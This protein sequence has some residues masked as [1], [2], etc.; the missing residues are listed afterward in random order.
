MLYLMSNLKFD[1]HKFMGSIKRESISCQIYL[2][3]FLN[4]MPHLFHF[5]F[6]YV[7]FSTTLG[8]F[9]ATPTIWQSNIICIWKYIQNID[10]I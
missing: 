2:S 4:E 9:P 8:P 6:F 10:M 7:R 3:S 5:L 1:M